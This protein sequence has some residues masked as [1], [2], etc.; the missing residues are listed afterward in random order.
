MMCSMHNQSSIKLPSYS[1]NHKNLM[2]QQ[3]SLKPSYCATKCTLCFN[4]R[5]EYVYQG[6]GRRR[7]GPG[8]F[9]W[10]L[11]CRVTSDWISW[12]NNWEIISIH[13][14]FE[15]QPAG[16]IT[17]DPPTTKHS[18][19]HDPP[20]T[21]NPKTSLKAGRAAFSMSS[22]CFAPPSRLSFPLLN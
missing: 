7:V 17:T 4:I 8:S 9:L 14:L 1:I 18:S 2:P 12:E 3:V 20:V 16:D 19:A 10:W 6:T 21:L 5:W 11:S 13:G 15:V 22:S